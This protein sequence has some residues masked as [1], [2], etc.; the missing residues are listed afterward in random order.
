MGHRQRTRKGLQ[1]A[2]MG[3]AAHDD[4][5]LDAGVDRRRA[6]G[7]ASWFRIAPR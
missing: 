4:G 7:G 5:S 2:A 3:I 1:G 6:D